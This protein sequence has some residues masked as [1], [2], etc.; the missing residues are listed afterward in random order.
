[1]IIGTIFG[2]SL[3]KENGN[4]QT[5]GFGTD[6]FLSLIIQIENS[7]TIFLGIHNDCQYNGHCRRT[8][9]A[10]KKARS[11]RD[12]GYFVQHGRSRSKIAITNREADQTHKREIAKQEVTK[13][14][15]R[16]LTSDHWT[17]FSFEWYYSP[18]GLV[19]LVHRIFKRMDLDFRTGIPSMPKLDIV[20]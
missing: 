5:H 17:S 4:K 15:K 20:R 13:C 6:H 7:I 19:W 8:T 2:C 3:G 16:K 18:P 14:S 9:F 1:M 12:I 11:G 10:R